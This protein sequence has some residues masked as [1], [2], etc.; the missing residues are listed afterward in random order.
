VSV[1][2]TNKIITATAKKA[3][4]TPAYARESVFLER[5]A[6]WCKAQKRPQYEAS[7]SGRRKRGGFS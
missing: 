6:A 5:K 7:A 3:K 4:Q 1:Y 2:F